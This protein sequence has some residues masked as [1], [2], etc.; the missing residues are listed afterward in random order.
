MKVGFPTAAKTIMVLAFATGGFA[1][2]ARVAT[3]QSQQPRNQT[4]TQTQEGLPTTQ[5]RILSKLGPEDVFGTP[6]DES[7]RNGSGGSRQRRLGPTPTPEAS[8]GQTAK[9]IAAPPMRPSPTPNPSGQTSSVA[10]T[11]DNPSTEPNRSTSP[12]TLNNEVPSALSS[13][14]SA[15]RLASK[16]A[17]P[18]LI[19]LALLV[20]A[21]LIF[22]LTKL[23]EKIREGSSG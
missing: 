3:A 6:P 19:F 22:T 8:P 16:W 7:R 2:T 18:M 9:S 10:P 14:D 4:Q 1:F 15:A 12:P 5:K 21:A 13:D 17:A 23:V 11:T 20:S